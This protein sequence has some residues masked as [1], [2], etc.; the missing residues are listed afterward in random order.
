MEAVELIY[1]ILLGKES[2]ININSFVLR[3]I[4]IADATAY[5]LLIR[6]RVYDIYLLCNDFEFS[7]ISINYLSFRFLSLNLC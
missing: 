1:L 6:H 2:L 5:P 3:L 7:F 4:Q